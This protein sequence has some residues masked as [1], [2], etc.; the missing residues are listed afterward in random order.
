MHVTSYSGFILEF[1]LGGEKLVAYDAWYDVFFLQ[2]SQTTY[3]H[4]I[5]MFRGGGGRKLSFKGG[6]EEFSLQGGGD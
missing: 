2:K 4:S 5:I 1:S 6:G 3:I